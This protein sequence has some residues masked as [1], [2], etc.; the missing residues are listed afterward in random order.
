MVHGT[1]S[2]V[3]AKVRRRFRLDGLLRKFG[4]TSYN[5]LFRTLWPTVGSIDING[6]PKIMSRKAFPA[7]GLKSTQWFLDPEIMIKSHAL[8]MRVIEFNVFARLRG[9]GVSHVKPG[10]C[11]E[12]LRNLVKF[13]LNGRSKHGLM[14]GGRFA[15]AAWLLA[16][17]KR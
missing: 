5:L 1:D 17:V 3:V 6:S 7:M 8:G 9:G 16:N 15:T 10:T 13:R 2:W 4:S 11:V 12:F 14:R